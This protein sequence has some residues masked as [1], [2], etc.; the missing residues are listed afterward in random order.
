[1]AVKFIFHALP[2]IPL[3]LHKPNL[4]LAAVLAVGIPYIKVLKFKQLMVGAS[5]Q[6]ASELNARLLFWKRLTFLR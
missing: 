1:M 4:T 5:D 3:V 6:V 2:L